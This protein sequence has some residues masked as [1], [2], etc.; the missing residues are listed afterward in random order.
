MDRCT[1][2]IDVSLGDNPN[3]S[4]P[5]GNGVDCLLDDGFGIDRQNTDLDIVESPDLLSFLPAVS[6]HKDFQQPP[7]RGKR[8]ET[9]RYP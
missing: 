3:I 2:D 8:I 7:Q 6:E 4:D 5:V 1:V 9:E